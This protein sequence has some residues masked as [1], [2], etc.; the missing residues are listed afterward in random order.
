VAASNLTRSRSAVTRTV[1]RTPQE[2]QLGHW[3]IQI[4]APFAP[5]AST[6]EA[7]GLLASMVAA[8]PSGSQP[9]AGS[10]PVRRC[11]GRAGRG[12]AG[13]SGG[14]RGRRRARPVAR[15][16]STF[17]NFW[18]V[19]V[20]Q[21]T[22]ARPGSESRS[23]SLS[24]RLPVRKPAAT[25]SSNLNLKRPRPFD[26]ANLKAPGRTHSGTARA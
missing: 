8:G 17:E 26:S 10:M 25:A 7:P 13:T 11:R 5:S 16:R 23:P 6:C 21:A 18:D 14:A 1:T 24:L 15:P 12:Q 9:Q 3:Q 22:V 4:G 20:C 19:G 2:P